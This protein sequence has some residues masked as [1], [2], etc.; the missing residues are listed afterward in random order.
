MAGII[1]ADDLRRLQQ[2]MNR[3]MQ[4]LGLSYME[5]RYLD[6]MNRI[7]Q[8]LGGIV[9][10]YG[11]AQIGPNTMMPLADIRETDDSVIVT[12]DLPGVDKQGVNISVTEDGLRV[13]AEARK[14]IEAGGQSGETYHKRERTF[15]RFERMVTLP[16]AVNGD[17]AT[18]R[19]ENGILTVTLPKEIVISRKRINIE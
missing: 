11:T 2:C 9:G 6:E 16:V 18:A 7:S 17:Q 19:L 1:P 15:N 4:D 8:R 3:L 5:S 10:E 13:V 12:M 14:E